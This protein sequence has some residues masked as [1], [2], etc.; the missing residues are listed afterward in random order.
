MDDSYQR[1]CIRQLED[2][3]AELRGQVADA[4]DKVEQLRQ[5]SSRFDIMKDDFEQRARRQ[6]ARAQRAA[7]IANAPRSVSS[8]AR[9]LADLVSGNSYARSIDSFASSKA[10]IA[11]AM[12]RGRVQIE[13]ANSEIARC[14]L[15][16]ERLH[17]EIQ[18]MA[19]REAAEQAAKLAAE[20]AAKLAAGAQGV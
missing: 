14:K 18:L 13:Q 3:I 17:E 6:R 9:A 8:Y 16:I 4:E 2:R 20:E 15:E 12:Q 10:N 5:L 19:A 7:G 11:A 1:L